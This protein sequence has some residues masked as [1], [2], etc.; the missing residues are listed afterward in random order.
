MNMNEM[1]LQMVYAASQIAQSTLP[2]ISN[3]NQQSGETKDFHS[4]LSEKRTQ[5]E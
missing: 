5:A 2:P 1:L 4:L 3:N